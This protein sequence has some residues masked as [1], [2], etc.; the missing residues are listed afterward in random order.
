MIIYG[1]DKVII[2]RA[3]NIILMEYQITILFLP[4]LLLLVTYKTKNV[5][6]IL[7]S[8]PRTCFKVV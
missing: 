5:S 2:K 7:V 3:L 8:I 6:I 1:S 4:L